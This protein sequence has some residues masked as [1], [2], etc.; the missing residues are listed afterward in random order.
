MLCK[1]A[2]G[3]HSARSRIAYAEK[4]Q[5]WLRGM[6]SGYRK[7]RH[8]MLKKSGAT[9]GNAAPRTFTLVARPPVHSTTNLGGQSIKPVI[10]QKNG[11]VQLRNDVG[12]ECPRI[13]PG[14]TGTWKPRRLNVWDEL[15]RAIGPSAAPNN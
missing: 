5:R 11:W 6:V 14:C 8:R 3:G 12:A 15:R 13:M 9:P 2:P 4:P 10:G 7:N 1:R